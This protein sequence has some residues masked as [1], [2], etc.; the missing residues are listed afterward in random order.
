MQKIIMLMLTMMTTTTTT[1]IMMMMV[2]LH[3]QQYISFVHAFQIPS[4]SSS[5]SSIVMPT[6][7]PSSR[8]RTR[9]PMIQKI[10]KQK[11]FRN[12][13][14]DDNDGVA[15]ADNDHQDNTDDGSIS[16][17]T[18]SSSSMVNVK[19]EDIGSIAAAMVVLRSEFVLKTTGCGLPA[20]PYGVV[21]A[22]E[23]LSYV[24]VVLTCA[25][26]IANYVSSSA[27]TAAPAV[28]VKRGVDDENSSSSSTSNTITRTTKLIAI[29]LSSTAILLGIIV[30][31]FQVLDYGYIPNAVPMKGGMCE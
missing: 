10:T 30:V 11:L 27:A 15:V 19:K 22:M 7:T 12:N 17:F 9:S 26:A 5:S 13:D 6:R 29:V 18:S 2:A 31:I 23:G 3:Y 24:A 14:G 25:T 8:T 20:G 21:G 4:F 28:V 16:S 1:I